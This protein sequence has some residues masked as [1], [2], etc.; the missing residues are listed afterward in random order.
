MSLRKLITHL[1]ERFTDWSP[2][3]VQVT[4]SPTPTTKR[5][6]S[7]VPKAVLWRFA[8]VLNPKTQT[9]VWVETR[10]DG[11]LLKGD[12]QRLGVERATEWHEVRATSRAEARKLIAE[13]KAERRTCTP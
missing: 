12:A 9:T 10:R 4:P 7:K 1:R 2:E 6:Q 8:Q 3:T 11:F 5:R 13:G